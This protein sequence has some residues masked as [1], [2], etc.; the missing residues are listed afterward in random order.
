[1]AKKSS[2]F[3]SAPALTSTP[4]EGFL[5]ENNYEPKVN[6]D[7]I[8]DSGDSG[9]SAVEQ[10]LLLRLQKVLFSQMIQESPRE[11][12]EERGSSNYLSHAFTS[13]TIGDY[14]DLTSM[15]FSGFKNPLV[16]VD[17]ILHNLQPITAFRKSGDDPGHTYGIERSENPKSIG[18]APSESD[19]HPNFATSLAAAL[20]APLHRE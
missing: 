5:S 11:D 16:S 9:D 10:K 1:M 3:L 15:G 7:N 20:L 19:V 2:H 14:Q 13:C 8:R 18:G 17:S 12:E 6:I 4:A